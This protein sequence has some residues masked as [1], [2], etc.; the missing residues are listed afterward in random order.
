MSGTTR[1]EHK[2]SKKADRK[3]LGE[4]FREAREYLGFSQEEVASFLG[5]ARSA[6]SNIE[7]GQRKVES[8]ELKKLA[9][10]Y[11]RPIGYFAGEDENEGDLPVGE[12]VAHLARK[13]A[14]LS[15][16]DRAELTRFVDYLRSRS[17]S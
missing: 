2:P 12:D 16:D 17:K 10:L 1:K 7:A 15:A 11:K 5:I 3:T 14:H 6:M 9:E 4:R 13:V 8:L